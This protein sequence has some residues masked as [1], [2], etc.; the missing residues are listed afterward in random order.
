MIELT[1]GDMTCGHCASTITRTVKEID[2]SGQC[3]VDL[4]AKRVR[5]AS[6]RPAALFVDA[7]REAGFT[8]VL[9]AE[10][11]AA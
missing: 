8:P 6:E 5:I 11:G 1:V 3:E 9:A 2:A 10:G 4:A 7:I